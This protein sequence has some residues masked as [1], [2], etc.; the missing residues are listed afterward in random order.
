[1][2]KLENFIQLK[3]FARQDGALL[4]ILWIASFAA[5]IYTPQTPIG[6]ILALATPFFI[7]WRLIKFRNYA[8]NG[9]ISFRRGFAYSIYTVFYASA[10]FAIMQYLYF[11]FLDNNMFMTMITETMEHIMPIY[12][13]NG[14][15]V[16]EINNELRMMS[17]LSPIQWAFMFM[18]QNIFIGFII[19]F[20]I[21]AVCTRR[22]VRKIKINN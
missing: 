21:A 16:E 11:R 3:A 18:I 8:L 22:P 4:S 13:E 12:A 2:I 6:N 9:A 10:I 15:P 19:G 1:M 14:F 20:P 17:E 7:G 5:T